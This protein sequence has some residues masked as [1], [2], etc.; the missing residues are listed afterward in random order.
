MESKGGQKFLKT[1]ARKRKFTLGVKVLKKSLL[2][3]L[4][5]DDKKGA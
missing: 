3:N 2:T 5:I 4:I 1:T